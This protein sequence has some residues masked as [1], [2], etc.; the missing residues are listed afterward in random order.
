ME[1]N[2]E[3]ILAPIA[4]YTHS[5]FRQLC[6]ELGADRTYSELINAMSVIKNRKQRE[7]TYFLDRERPTH[8]QV[9][10]RNAGEISEAAYILASRYKPDAIDI[11]FGCSVKKALKA[12][13]AGYLLQFPREMGRIVS[14][15]VEAVRPL[16]LPV[17]AKIRLGFEN[18]NLEAIA[19]E[20]ISNGISVIALHARTAKQGFSGKANWDRI[21]R[22]KEIAKDIPIIGNGDIK[23]WQDI[24]GMFGQTGCDG[25]MIGRA[26]ISNPWIFREYKLRS[27]ISKSLSERIE[28]ILRELELMSKFMERER[29]CRMIKSQIVALVKG[30]RGKS[31]LNEMVMRSKSCDELIGNL[32]Q[33][34]LLEET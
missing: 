22:L 8:L 14:Q 18:D 31:R 6:K 4:G 11:N 9:Y 26:A 1:I 32:K 7:L 30:I 23:S 10:G 21:K 13:A 25:V 12:K 16:N 33:R 29:A 3:I 17:T 5:A 2:R 15:T 24:D 34:V 19:D 20:L 28:F 27:S